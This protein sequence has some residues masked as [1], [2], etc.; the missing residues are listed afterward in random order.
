MPI[1]DFPHQRLDDIELGGIVTVR[2]RLLA[3]Q[4]AGKTVLRLES[5]DPSFDI[6]PHVRE[7][8]ERA[9]REGK[10]HYTPGAGIPEL[11]AAIRD[12]LARDNGISL[13]G[14][15]EVLVTSGAMHGL[16]VTF[17]SLL[18]PGEKVIVPD[19]SWTETVDNIR[20]AGGVP[21][22]APLDTKIGRWPLEEVARRI[23]PRTRAIAINT[24]H[25]PT[26]IVLDETTLRG[27]G[28]L[29]ERH[30]L[31]IVSDEAYEHVIFD[32][33]RHVSIASLGLPTEQV[34]SLFSMSKSYAMSGLRMG[35][36]AGGNKLFRERAAK[37]IR[38]TVNGVNSVAQHGAVA[39][40]RGPQEETAKMQAVYQTRRDTLMQGLKDARHIQA[41]EPQGAFYVWARIHE[42][43]PGY[44]GAKDGW[45][46][47]SYLIDEA[48]VGSAPGEV[49][50]PAGRGHVRFAFSCA[51]EQVQRAAG[52]LARLLA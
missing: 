9:L 45:A 42:S 6:A 14:P 40:L 24:P 37:L 23:G 31:Y 27:L 50:G 10:T 46:M 16:Y 43:W 33:R 49:F 26:G 19:P 39:A 3:M 13:K 17:A 36:M 48:G 18:A 20:L 44:K 52:L 28:D 21:V 35:Y 32:G 5:G 12:K 51:S 25:N 38:C 8:M 47:T 11:R 1:V 29:A 30:G 15:E 2:D 34:V 41:L 4:A 22:L 7:A